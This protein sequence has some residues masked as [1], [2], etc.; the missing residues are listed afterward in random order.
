MNSVLS[1]TLLSA[2]FD[3]A[4]RITAFK[5]SAAARVLVIEKNSKTKRQQNLSNT[6]ANQEKSVKAGCLLREAAANLG[7][8]K[9]LALR[10]ARLLDPVNGRKI[11]TIAAHLQEPIAA[12]DEA[13]HVHC[14]CKPVIL[15]EAR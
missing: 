11:K 13:G 12:L 8:G 14:T 2:K 4:P 10:A 1:S 6:T 15:V 3:A 7:Q 9:L 5:K